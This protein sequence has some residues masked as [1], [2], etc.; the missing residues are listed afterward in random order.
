MRPIANL[1][2]TRDQGGAVELEHYS[3]GRSPPTNSTWIDLGQSEYRLDVK[4]RSRMLW[5]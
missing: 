3:A 4:I 5:P 2:G 1:E